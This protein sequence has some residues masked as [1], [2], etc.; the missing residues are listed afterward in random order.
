MD[1]HFQ[2]AQ[3]SRRRADPGVAVNENFG[4]IL[5]RPKQQILVVFIRAISFELDSKSLSIA[6]V[7]DALPSRSIHICHVLNVL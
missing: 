5:V 2:V 6:N 7:D 1:G 4:W 3:I